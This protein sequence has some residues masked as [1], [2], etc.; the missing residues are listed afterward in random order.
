MKVTVNFTYEKCWAS[1]LVHQ[2][3]LIVRLLSTDLIDPDNKLAYEYAEVIGDN[4]NILK[5]LEALKDYPDIINYKII[6]ESENGKRMIIRVYLRLLECPLFRIMH[7]FS[8]NKGLPIFERVGYDGSLYWDLSIKHKSTVE[9]MVS[10]LR[11]LGI[12]QINIRFKKERELTSKTFYIL[13]FA[14]EKG[15]FDVKRKITLKELSQ[16][17]NIPVS[18]LNMALRRAVKKIMDETIK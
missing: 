8:Q 9:R 7:A 12:K 3:N 14:Y 6:K 18:T 2:Y 16:E 11:K 13:K 17:L 15:Y 5:A 4:K 10:K 1:M